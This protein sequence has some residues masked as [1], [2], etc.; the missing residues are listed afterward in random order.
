MANG[1]TTKN[2]R[3]DGKTDERT[4]ASKGQTNDRTCL[5]PEEDTSGQ[6]G[7]KEGRK[8]GGGGGGDSISLQESTLGTTKY[9]FLSFSTASSRL[10]DEAFVVKA[11]GQVTVS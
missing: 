8:G 11:L 4:K 2:E 7:R 1:R 10:K 6:G 9:L 3:K 5:W